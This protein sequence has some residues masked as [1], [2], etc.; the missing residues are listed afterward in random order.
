MKVLPIGEL[1]ALPLQ[2]AIR[3]QTLAFQE[4]ITC[5]EQM[6]LEEGKARTFQFRTER[7]VEERVIDP[8]TGEAKTQFRT[9][10]FEVSLPLLAMVS[11][12]GLQLQEMDVEFGVEVTEPKAEPIKAAAVPPAAR[13]SSLSASLALFTARGQS[14]PAPSTMK[15]NMKIIRQ[16]PEGMARV[17]DMLVDL[18]SARIVEEPKI[19]PSE[20]GPPAK[21]IDVQEIRG[22]GPEAAAILRGKGIST[23][24][25]FLKATETAKSREELAKTIGR[26]VSAKRIETWREVGR[27]VLKSKEGM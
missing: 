26:G 2:S 12:P 5:I 18:L 17:S 27:L 13:G 14:N 23:I 9:Q 10:P 16:I 19:A 20:E 7:M 15:V 21:A 25:E 3:A 8:N 11:L 6:G 24:T 1:F 4:T 22:I